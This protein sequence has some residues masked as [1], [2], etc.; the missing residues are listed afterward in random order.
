MLS[1]FERLY[2]AFVANRN[3]AAAARSAFWIGNKIA[4]LGELAR[5]TGWFRRAQDLLEN[6]AQPC[7]EHGYLLLPAAR[8]RM[9][10]GDSAAA[11]AAALEAL[12]IGKQFNDPDLVALAQG[13]C[14]RALL[15]LGRVQEG[16]S[17][18]DEVMLCVTRREISPVVAGL[19]YCGMIDCCHRFYAFDRAREWTAALTVWCD[20]QP[21]LVTFTGT[22]LVHRVELMEIGGEW[23]NA[24]NEA[25]RASDRVARSRDP[26]GVIAE[27]YYRQAEILRLR[28]QFE[29]AEQAYCEASQLGREP[30][31]GLALL[32]LAQGNKDAA[33]NALRRILDSTRDPLQRL[34]FLPA[35]IEALVHKGERDRA[36]RACEE[37]EATA[38]STRTPVLTAMALHARG[39]LLLAQGDAAGAIASLRPAFETWHALGAPYR[40]AQIRLLMG[41][42]CRALGD[43]DGARLDIEAAREVF[44]RLGAEPDRILAEQWAQGSTECERYGLTEREMQVLRL[45]AT[46]KTNK[47]IAAD[48]HLSE[49]TIDRH[50]NNIFNKVNVNSRAAATAFAY[51]HRL[52]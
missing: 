31:P 29:L 13:L 35:Y 38:E 40:A 3:Q 30:Q 19:V 26:D 52:V 34:R 10:E 51:E 28:G 25:Q 14:A 11:H 43:A 23:G 50:V 2:E 36:E 33:V 49:K 47:S 44:A 41:C 21:Q 15:Q 4:A 17:T 1:A 12:H 18:L 39:M 45:I 32:R 5:A 7:V 24:L 37:L 22:C 46:G 16:L 48:L 20:R 42:A 6:V 8:H 9:A 27:A